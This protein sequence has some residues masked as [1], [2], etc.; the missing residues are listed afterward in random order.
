M[1]GKPLTTAAISPFN[2]SGEGE[3]PAR[4]GFFNGGL[5]IA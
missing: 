1:F 2:F 5:L 4:K 3:Y